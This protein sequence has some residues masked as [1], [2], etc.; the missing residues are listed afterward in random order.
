MSGPW[1]KLRRSS[2]LVEIHT[3]HTDAVWLYTLSTVPTEMITRRCAV[4]K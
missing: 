1:M 2:K 3:H 4:V